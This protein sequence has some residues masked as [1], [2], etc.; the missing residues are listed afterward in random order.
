MYDIGKGQ[1]AVA[2][3]AFQDP[4][5]VAQEAHLLVSRRSDLVRLYNPNATSCHLSI[6][7]GAGRRLVQVLNYSAQPADSLT[8]WVNARV[9]PGT[10]WRLGAKDA[11]AVRDVAAERGTY[12]DLPS[13]SVYGALECGGSSL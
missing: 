5:Q 12:F 2:E 1:I 11:V 8:L 9:G 4:Y 13:L 6:D 3:E 10:L 7:P